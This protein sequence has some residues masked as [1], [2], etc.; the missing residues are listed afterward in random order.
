[1][2]ACGMILENGA[3]LQLRPLEPE[4]RD[5]LRALFA[6]LSPESRLKRFLS[7]KPALTRRELDYLTDIDHLRH[8]AIAAIDCGNQSIIGVARYVAQRD[9]AGTAELAAEVADE[10]QGFG[11]GTALARHIIKRARA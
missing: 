8:E 6:R 7:P 1:M 5:R 4:D 11:I 2:T 10:F 3:R 9:D